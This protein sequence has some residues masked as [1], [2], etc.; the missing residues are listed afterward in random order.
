MIEK[1]KNLMPGFKSSPM[2]VFHV[3]LQYLQGE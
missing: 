3:R 2:I 1:Y